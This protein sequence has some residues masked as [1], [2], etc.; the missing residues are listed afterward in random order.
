MSRK[1]EILEKVGEMQPLP[2]TVL[3]LINVVNDPASTV[4]DIVETIKYDQGATTQMLRICNSAYFGLSREIGTLNEAIRYL[5]TMKVLQLVMAI[6][7]NALLV[8]GQTGYGL[9]PGTLWKHSAAVAVAAGAFAQRIGEEQVNTAFTA[10]LLHDIGKVVLS[11]HVADEFNQIQELVNTRKAT[12]LEAEHEILGFSHSEI[13]GLIAEKWQLPDPI[14]RCIRYH[15][16]PTSLGLPDTLV[17]TVYLADSVCML[18]GIGGGSD[19]LNYRAE[20]E[21]MQRYDLN[22]ADLEMMGA[23]VMIEIKRVQQTFEDSSNAAD[24]APAGAT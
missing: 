3:R 18:F 7:S 11:E 4:N 24:T 8:K 1:E 23:Q 12:F 16:E 2:T 9:G 5:G 19:G 15:H 14:V 21:V 20:P 22:E 6:H 10:G 17:D 13:G